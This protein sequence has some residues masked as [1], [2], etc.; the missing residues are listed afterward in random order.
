V[1]I[2]MIYDVEVAAM[3]N[4]YSTLLQENR[5]LTLCDQKKAYN[6]VTERHLQA[7][8]LEQ[9]YFKNL[10]TADGMPIEV[11][12]AGIWNLEAGPDFRKAHLRIAG[13]DYHGDIEIHLSEESWHQHHHHIDPRY[14]NV[15]L[16]I[17]LWK[18]RKASPQHTTEGHLLLSSYL[19]D[20]LTIPLAR[21][22]QLVDLELYPYRK[23]IGSGRCAQELFKELPKEE[24]LALLHA[25]ADWRLE[26]KRDSLCQR[27]A[28]PQ[29]Q[30]PAAIAMA[31][32]Y[33]NNNEIFLGLYLEMQQ[34]RW[35]T[36][37]YTLA[38]L[39][40]RCGFLQGKYRKMW[41]E[42]PY[43]QQM[44]LIAASTAS[45]LAL[46]PLP[47]A[48]QQVRPLNHPVRRLAYLAKMAHDPSWKGLPAAI[49][50]VW[51]CQWRTCLQSKRWKP[52]FEELKAL[53]PAYGDEYWNSHYLFELELRSQH[54]PLLGNDLRRE[55]A[56][57]S[58]FP[59]L[60]GQIGKR[61]DDR[62][63]EA[64][65]AFYRSLPAL[66]SGKQ[67]YL[68]HRL[69]GDTAKGSLLKRAYAQQGA[70]QLH[71]DFCVHYEASCEGC[72]FVKR[73]RQQHTRLEHQ[74]SIKE[75]LRA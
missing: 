24:T 14:N 19:E 62:E 33:K 61:G 53:L 75:F 36:E 50:T 11:L 25:A 46:A 70:F 66:K 21:L 7:I 3:G 40:E 13:S 60:D 67:R 69:F 72:P 68:T 71:Y 49:A 10:A 63:R 57:N 8:W 64:F 45:P 48:T 74:T 30:L 54:L 51:E 5:P 26:R 65:A 37:Q 17:A 47:I 52:L 58:F 15:I 56:I 35:P 16:H 22:V 4:C 23:F 42:S 31:L 38:W 28:D 2:G 18:P 12:S 29:L 39:L 6:L 1:K 32:G 20:F 27:V 34:K 55:I 44:L 9:K 59:L 43:Y 41:A 73:Y